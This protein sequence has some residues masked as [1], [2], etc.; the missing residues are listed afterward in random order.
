M[1]DFLEK[2]DALDL[3][4]KEETN[5]FKGSCD[6]LHNCFD[7]LDCQTSSTDHETSDI[8]G[9]IKTYCD[10]IIYIS[11]KFVECSDKLEE[12]S[13]QCFENWDPFPNDIE[14]ETDQKKKEEM[15]KSAC[16]NFF[17]KDNCLKEE[18]VSSCSE[19]EWI[20]FRDVR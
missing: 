11:T 3:D 2:I 16:Q 6:S 20:G 5:D 10:T 19:G 1:Q 7:A 12:K 13:S 4:N 17:G 14:K 15:R 18:I 8:S 9:M